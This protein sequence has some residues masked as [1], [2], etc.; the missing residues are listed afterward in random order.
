MEKQLYTPLEVF[1]QENVALS[2]KIQELQL[3]NARIQNQIVTLQ[4]QQ[5][6]I[7][8]CWCREKANVGLK[9]KQRFNAIFKE[10]T[11]EDG[12]GEE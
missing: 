3:M 4:R 9:A 11:H 7:F 12:K 1:E 2:N 8:R 5:E 10:D 6:A